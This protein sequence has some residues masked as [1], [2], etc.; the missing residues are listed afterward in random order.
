MGFFSDMQCENLIKLQE[1][2]LTELWGSADDWVPLEFLVSL[3]SSVQPCVNYAMCQLHGRV[4][5]PALLPLEL[6][7]PVSCD[8]LYLSAHLSSS[9]SSS[10]LCDLPSLVN[11]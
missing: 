5:C 2:H 9:Q 1:L 11:L 8:S 3:T 7:A 6:S 10:V 4:S